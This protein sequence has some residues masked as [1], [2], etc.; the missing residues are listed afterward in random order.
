M[1]INTGQ[2][3]RSLRLK[4]HVSQEELAE[5]IGVTIQAISKWETGKAN[6]DIMLLP[7]LAEY[8][9]IAIDNLFYTNEAGSP[10]SDNTKNLL[11]QN[12]QWWEGLEET[13]ILEQN[14]CWWE[15]VEE[16][17]LVTT[18]L[19]GYG[20]FTPTE[21]T[22]C[23]LGD[24]RGKIMLEIACGSGGSLIW[25]SRK[26]AKELYGLDISATQ[27]KR[28]KQLLKENGQYLLSKSYVEEQDIIYSNNS[29]TTYLHNWKTS[30]Y[31]NCLAKHGF[32]IEQVVEESAYHEQEAAVFQEEK[33]YS[34]GKA[35][36]LNPSIIIK[37]RKL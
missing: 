35:K 18:S 4:R 29:E 30:S 13:D 19:P 10:D 34:A 15:G 14:S 17:G 33:F 11:E 20:F 37:A 6:P 32:L 31:L 1:K 16:S 25:A 2:N 27:I 7:K 26:G 8:F 5:T 28:A 9:G 24:I 22:L 12:S 3:I 36:L 23:L 21:D